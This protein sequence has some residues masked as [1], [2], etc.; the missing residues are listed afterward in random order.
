M[1]RAT[2]WVSPVE[3]NRPHGPLRT[4][5]AGGRITLVP[6]QP[7]RT[8]PRK[9]AESV[10]VIAAGVGLMAFGTFGAFTDATTP[11]PPAPVAAPH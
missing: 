10:V 3:V 8:V 7:A 9:I 2:R 11:F 4:V 5:T 6:Q 1:T